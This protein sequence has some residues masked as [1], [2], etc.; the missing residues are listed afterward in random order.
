[1][2]EHQ[3]SS[4]VAYKDGG[5]ALLLGYL[6]H[7]FSSTTSFKA[8]Q[9]KIRDQQWSPFLQI[10]RARQWLMSEQ[11]EAQV[12]PHTAGWMYPYIYKLDLFGFLA[13]TDQ[14]L[15]QTAAYV[16]CL[17]PDL[18]SFYALFPLPNKHA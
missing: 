6:L 4:A 1:M 11:A 7:Q 12:S 10:N 16:N 3:S 17:L 9:A 8:K 5:L 13:R 18:S 2:Q 15:C 14:F